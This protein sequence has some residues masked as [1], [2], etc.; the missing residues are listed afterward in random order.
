LVVKPIGSLREA[1]FEPG[2]IPESAADTQ[3]LG[4]QSGVLARRGRRIRPLGSTLA[5]RHGLPEQVLDLTVDAAQIV[6]G[7]PLELLPELGRHTQKERLALYRH[8]V[9]Y[10]AF[11]C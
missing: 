2:M 8:A 4:G 10:T 11:P 7:P 6:R 1:R 5:F 9:S 3:S